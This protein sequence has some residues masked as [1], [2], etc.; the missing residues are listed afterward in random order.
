MHFLASLIHETVRSGGDPRSGA[1]LLKA[2]EA[3]PV[4]QNYLSGGQVHLLSDHGSVRALQLQ[5]VKDGKYV[6]IK[7][8]QPP[9]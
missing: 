2:L 4:F 1:A 8:V 3:H 9:K 7:V 5:Q 6:T